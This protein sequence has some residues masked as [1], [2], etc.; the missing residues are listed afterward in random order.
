MKSLFFKKI[1]SS[2]SLILFVS[3]LTIIYPFWVGNDYWISTGT[4]FL[5]NALLISS[6]V[7]VMGWAGQ[8]SLGH[9]SL[10]AIGA[11]T[12]ALL[13]VRLEIPFI[14]CFI[15]AGIMATL[16]AF[17]I[18]LPSLRLR[19]HYLAMATLGFGEIVSILLV[20][21]D[22]LTGGTGGITGIPPASFGS[23]VIKEPLPYYIF[24]WAIT[25]LVLVGIIV[26]TNSKYG[27]AL[28]AVKSN[29]VAS[30]SLG[31][32]TSFLKLLA[33]TFSGFIAGLAGSLY[34]HLNRFISPDTFSI[35]LSIILVAMVVIGGEESL[36]GALLSAF[37]LTVL[38]EYL[39]GFQDYNP[40]M[41]GAALIFITIFAR[42][43]LAGLL[44][45]WFTLLEGLL[46]AGVNEN[47]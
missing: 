25:I 3:I 12:S 34:A 1:R 36:G 2:T 31:L 17:I 40:L 33:F 21:S 29:E 18:G 39:R 45:K 32:N 4:L 16:F 5:I 27:R 6:L 26:F 30:S 35:S 11:Y 38:E 7:V 8:I 9:A 24:T 13:T 42:K 22:D 43:G 41:F 14:I 47:N 37:V 15:S 44:N 10:Y 20:E 19:G 46:G 28:K 23:L